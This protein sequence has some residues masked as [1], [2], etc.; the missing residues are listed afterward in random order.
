MSE[1]VENP[2]V[3][4]YKEHNI[5]P[6]HQ[7]ISVFSQHMKRREKL[8]RSLGLPPFVFHK[9]TVLEI[10]PGGG[11][12]A[13]AFFRWGATVDFVEPNKKA[14][15]ELPVLLGKCDIDPNDWNLF[16]GLIED[17]Y[18]EKLYNIVIAEGFIPGLLEK[19]K[20]DC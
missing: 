13:L 9:E 12:N 11:Y 17:Y 7:D 4:F 2:Y 10:G 15:D 5:S 8:Y 6:V 1:K 3:N 20:C 18:P 16:S 19:R 14:Q